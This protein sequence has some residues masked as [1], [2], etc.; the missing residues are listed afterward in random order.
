VPGGLAVWPSPWRAAAP[1]AIEFDLPPEVVSGS[2]SADL[3]IGLHDLMGRR[4]A[5]IA[6][7]VLPATLGRVSLGWD[8]SGVEGGRLRPG[9]YHVVVRSGSRGI[10]FRKRVVLAP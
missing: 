6:H 9:V 7:G 10:L 1:L 5:T 3:E 8:G 4:V 2:S